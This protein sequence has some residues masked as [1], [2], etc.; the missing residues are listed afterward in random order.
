MSPT[1]YRAP[2]RI[3]D[4]AIRRRQ[5]IPELNGRWV[6]AIAWASALAAALVTAYL[7]ATA[8]GRY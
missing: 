7:T 8:R 6:Q 2:I 3:I 5:L 4:P 1:P